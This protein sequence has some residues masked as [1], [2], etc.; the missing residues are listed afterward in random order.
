[1]HEY[2]E[3]NEM[4]LRISEKYFNFENNQR[5]IIRDYV[6]RLDKECCTYKRIPNN[7]TW[8]TVKIC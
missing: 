2:Y 3:F 6:R 1:M 5:S 4:H 7:N 8:N